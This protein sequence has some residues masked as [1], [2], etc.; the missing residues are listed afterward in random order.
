[1]LRYTNLCMKKNNQEKTPVF[2]TFQD[3]PKHRFRNHPEAPSRLQPMTG[4]LENVPFPEITWLDFFPASEGEVLLA[5]DP[6]L[7]SFL[8]AESAKGAHEFETSPSYVTASSYDLALG[9]AGAVLA[10][11]RKIL[12]QG[13]GRGFAIVRPPGHH[14]GPDRAM[15]FCLLNNLAIAAADTVTSGLKR[16]AILDIDAHHGNGTQA[17]FWH[18]P[19]VG[20]L[21]IHERDIFPGTG[22]I[23]DARH[24]LGRIINVP[25][26]SFSGNAVYL[27]IYE[28][29]VKPWLFAFEPEMIFV[30]AGF[31]THFSDPLTTLSLDTGGI[32]RL[33]QM[34]LDWA[35]ELCEGRVMYVLE[36]GYDP[37]ALTDNV[38]ACLAAMSGREAPVDHFGTAP[39]LRTSIDSLISDLIQRHHLE[40]I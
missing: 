11:S 17:I 3:A 28:R 31:D 24:A 29:L 33:S 13:K 1:M 38:R 4:W 32:Y 7:L 5:H 20:F 27:D 34:L 16:V 35:D 8:K 9:A 18:S 14:A 40:E 19:E 22:M 2:C 15:G 12:S 23:I 21:S 39:E 26:P 30:S 36:G 6:S 37:T 10:V 25:L